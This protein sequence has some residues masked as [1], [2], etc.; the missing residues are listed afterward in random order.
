M[1]C[2]SVV[3]ELIIQIVS[4]IQSFSERSPLHRFFAGILIGTFIWLIGLVISL[5]LNPFVGDNTFGETLLHD[6][7]GIAL[8][9]G[10]VITLEIWGLLPRP[11]EDTD[12]KEK[13]KETEE[14]S[15]S[16]SS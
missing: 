1:K 9:F 10:L 3:S 7:P 14:D 11:I 6:L 5:G 8:I 16:S 4:E 12:E 2:D 13:L 15:M